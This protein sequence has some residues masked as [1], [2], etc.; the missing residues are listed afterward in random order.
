MKANSWR[1]TEQEVAHIAYAM[2]KMNT[3][4]DSP[5]K[6]QLLGHEPMTREK[7]NNLYERFY[8]AALN[9]AKCKKE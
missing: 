5:N 2:G 3:E 9:S 8:N 1:L 6:N 7:I 4:N